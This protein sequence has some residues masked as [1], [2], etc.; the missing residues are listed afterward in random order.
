MSFNPETNMYE[1]YIYKIYNDINDR[2]YIGQ[3]TYT[4]DR[5]W[6][7][8]KLDATRDNITMPLHKTMRSYGVENFHVC[9]LLKIEKP[10]LDE[11]RDCLNDAERNAIEKYKSLVSENGLNV[12]PG[13]QDIPP[14]VINHRVVDKYDIHL[15]LLETFDSV[16]MAANLLSEVDSRTAIY[17]VCNHKAEAHYGFVWAFHGEKPIPPKCTI[18]KDTSKILY[19]RDENEY[20]LNLYRAGFNNKRVVVYNSFGDVV[21]IYDDAIVASDVLSLDRFE[22]KRTLNGNKLSLNNMIFRYEG[23]RFD[24]YHIPECLIPYDLYDYYGKYIMSFD[25]ARSLANYLGVADTS[26]ISRAAKR[27]LTIKHHFITFY[28]QELKRNS[29]QKYLY[30]MID[31]NNNI[32]KVFDSVANIIEYLTKTDP[33]GA[34][35]REPHITKAIKNHTKLN[36]YYWDKISGVDNSQSYKGD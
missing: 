12:L 28:G 9:E 26:N 16:T 4:I 6:K 25:N 35:L 21:D 13:G 2:V 11:L 30:H 10:S 14:G 15:H 31:D 33:N 20:Y 22:L 1:G 23:E 24:K 3:T 32:V 29:H 36:G 27:G 19:T 34:T 7:Q 8:H 5:R 17:A 18:G